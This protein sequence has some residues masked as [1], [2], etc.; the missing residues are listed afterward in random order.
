MVSVQAL[1]VG[2]PGLGTWVIDIVYD[3]GIV[4]VEQC[5]A[6][7]GGV[8]NP[9]FEGAGSGT[10]AEKAAAEILHDALV[11]SLRRTKEDA[12]ERLVRF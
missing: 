10:A 2:P 1:D 3:P 12:G 6:L 8:C 9:N 5:T 11:G 4:S 7:H